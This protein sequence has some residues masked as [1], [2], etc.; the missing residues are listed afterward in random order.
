MADSDESILDDSAARI[1]EKPF[2]MFGTLNQHTHTHKTWRKGD[3]PDLAA[4]D[5]YDYGNIQRKPLLLSKFRY[6]DRYAFTP[7][8]TII[9]IMLYIS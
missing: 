1:P 9:A 5:C 7:P 2:R 3:N 8:A 6:P 4:A